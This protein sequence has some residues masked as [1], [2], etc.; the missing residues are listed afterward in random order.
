MSFWYSNIVSLVV[1]LFLS[2]STQTAELVATEFF[3]QGDLEKNKL[4][5]QPLVRLGSFTNVYITVYCSRPAS[6]GTELAVRYL[7]K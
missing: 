5:T 4:N 1:L 6:L 3:E 2:H 7:I